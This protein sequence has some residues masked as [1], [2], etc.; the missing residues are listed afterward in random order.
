[1]QTTFK[2]IRISEPKGLDSDMSNMIIYFVGNFPFS[3]Y[4]DS[5]LLE[6]QTRVN[7]NKVFVD[8][9]D[10]DMS[11]MIINF[12]CFPEHKRGSKLEVH[13][14]ELVAVIEFLAINDQFT[15]FKSK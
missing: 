1:M 10:S 7:S 8:N 14:S 13:L 12:V 9:I 6:P 15:Q 11:N 3:L 5:G 2:S 4:L